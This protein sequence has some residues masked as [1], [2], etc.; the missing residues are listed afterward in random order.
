MSYIYKYKYIYTLERE[1]SY[2]Q[3]LQIRRK[4]ELGLCS[5]LFWNIVLWVLFFFFLQFS[6]YFASIIKRAFKI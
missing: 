5:T 4:P 1:I 6:G 3:N 2:I